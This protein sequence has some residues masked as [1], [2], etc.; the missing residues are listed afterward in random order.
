MQRRFHHFHIISIFVLALS[1]GGCSTTQISTS[2]PAVIN[3]Q[4]LADYDGAYDAPLLQGFVAAVTQKLLR[5]SPIPDQTLGVIVLNADEVNAFADSGY[6]YITRGLLALANSEAQL[7]GI[8]AHEIGHMVK[9]HKPFAR[10]RAA[11]EIAADDFAMRL[12]ARAGYNPEAH[13][14]F[15]NALG[16]YAA[17]LKTHSAESARDWFINHPHSQTRVAQARALAQDLAGASG[18]SGS[19]GRSAIRGQDLYLNAIDGLAFGTSQ[20]TGAIKGRRYI[21]SALRVQFEVPSA[22]VLQDETHRVRA[23]HAN[24]VEI[25]FD[26]A[27]RMAK[28][29]PLA[30]LQNSWAQDLHPDDIRLRDV[31]GHIAAEAHIRETARHASLLVVP[32]SDTQWMRFAIF[33]PPNLSGQAKTTMGGVRRSIARLS[34][35]E[36]QRIRPHRLRVV[37]VSRGDSIGSLARRMRVGADKKELFLAL[38]GLKE[39]Q[40]QTLLPIGKSIKLIN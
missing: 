30:Y 31:A 4:L 21:H 8:I 25:V 29:T 23:H 3:A 13:A 37:L 9:R 1:L 26:L 20:S 7:A 2:A 40:A 16:H 33:S 12:A 36:A 34:A 38:N 18:S 32:Y 35:G 39:S 15:L 24:G 14:D 27:P 6:L 22:F 5:A 28:E 10:H 19:S 17:Y 11:Q